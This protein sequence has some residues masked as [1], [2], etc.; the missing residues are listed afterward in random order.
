MPPQNIPHT[1]RRFNL[2]WHV[3]LAL[4]DAAVL[5]VN[6]DFDNLVAEL[7]G[8]IRHLDLEVIPVGVYPPQVN[9][10]ERLAP[11]RLES[12][13]RILLTRMQD[14]PRIDRIGPPA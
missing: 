14:H 3:H 6:G 7:L 9:A 4:S 13:G 11:P 12:G 10:Q 2:D 5:E 1:Q 8:H